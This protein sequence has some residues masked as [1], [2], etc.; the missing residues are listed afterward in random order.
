MEIETCPFCVIARNNGD[1]ISKNGSFLAVYDKNPVSKGHAIIIPKRHIVSFFDLDSASMSDLL[2]IL[3]N[4]KDEIQSRFNPD[5]F[6]IGVN[7]GKAAGRTINHL[8][9]H[10]IP[11]YFGDVENPTGGVRSVI[12]GKADYTKK[13]V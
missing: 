9:I 7:D 1:M 6:N 13:P 2:D 12:P 4:V 8:H 11:R 3:T 5:G 10:L